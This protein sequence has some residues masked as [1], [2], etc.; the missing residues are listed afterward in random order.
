MSLSEARQASV[1]ACATDAAQARSVFDSAVSWFAA[2]SL[3]LK[4]P[5]AAEFWV[6][7]PTW[8][9]V[10]LVEH[11][12]RQWVPPGGKVEDGEEPREAAIR[13]VKEETGLS[14]VL[15]TFPAAAAVRSFDPKWPA[16]LSLSYSAFADPREILSPEDCQPTRWWP[17]EDHWPSAFPADRQRMLDH[18]ATLRH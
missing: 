8:S 6:F 15:D 5:L 18:L 13:E 1:S 12:W 14:V 10:L 7:D 17:L 16:T 3:T 4:A 9:S 2:N 11:R